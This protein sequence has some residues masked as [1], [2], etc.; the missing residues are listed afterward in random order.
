VRGHGEHGRADLAQLLAIA[1]RH[2]C[3]VLRKEGP[4][5]NGLRI[6]GVPS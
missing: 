3:T 6:K 4:P 5:A 2:T 1:P